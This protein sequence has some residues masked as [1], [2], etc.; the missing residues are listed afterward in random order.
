MGLNNKFDYLIQ[1]VSHIAVLQI[2][3]ISKLPKIIKLAVTNNQ[4]KCF[5]TIAERFEK[6]V[7]YSKLYFLAYSNKNL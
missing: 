1:P 4:T 7:V 2:L 5:F 6:F 3:N